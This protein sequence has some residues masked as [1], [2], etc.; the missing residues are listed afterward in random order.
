M[1]DRQNE[2]LEVLDVG[3]ERP[4]FEWRQLKPRELV[5]LALLVAIGVVAGAG[6]TWWWQQRE[7]ERAWASEAHV[8]GQVIPTENVELTNELCTAVTLQVINAGHRPVTLESVEV[9]LARLRTSPSC[10]KPRTTKPV[11]VAPLGAAKWTVPV[12]VDCSRMYGSQAFRATIRTESGTRHTESVLVGSYF[13]DLANCDSMYVQWIATDA[14][15]FTYKGKPALRMT[16]SF[17]VAIR[18]LTLHS[19][20]TPPDSAFTIVGSELPSEIGPYPQRATL[21]VVVS[22]CAAAADLP[23]TNFELVLNTRPSVGILSA[24]DGDRLEVTARL[25]RLVDQTCGK[26]P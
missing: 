16:G 12:Q 17:T 10:D 22:D 15:L 7:V 26:V 14:D 25:I 5:A 1:L 21:E 18:R 23:N 4:R 19:V 2:D 11:R 9:D 8:V 6:A 3:S 20:E 24:L 13:Q